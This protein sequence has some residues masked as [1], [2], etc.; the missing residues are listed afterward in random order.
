MR[1]I[2]LYLLTALV[3]A[4]VSTS[5][6]SAQ[7]MTDAE[8]IS[9]IKE[10]PYRA[11]ACHSPYYAPEVIYTPAPEG[12]E[13]F[14]VS[15]IGRHGSRFQTNGQEVY[16]TIVSLLDSLHFA[17]ALTPQGDSLRMELRH[18]QQAHLGMDGMLTGRGAAEHTGIA[19]RLAAR[20]PSVFNQADRRTV[21][22]TA[23]QKQRTIQSMAGFIAGLQ[24]VGGN[25]DY[26]INCGIDI[27]QYARPSDKPAN[28]GR[29]NT[30]ISREKEFLTPDDADLEALQHRLFKGYK[31]S[32]SDLETLFKASST[33]GCL[34]IKVDPFRFFSTEELFLFY[35]QYDAGF[36]AKYGT[37]APTRDDVA[38][39]GKAYLRMIVDEA[40]KALDGN[41]HCADFRFAHDT[42]LGPLMN[43]LGIGG[44]SISATEDAPYRYWQSF[45]QICMGSN[46][47]LE[48]YRNVESDVLVKALYNEKEVGFP[49]LESV[50]NVFYKWSD[51]RR[52]MINKCEELQEIPEYYVSHIRTKANEIR[53]LQKDELEGFYFITDMHFPDNRGHSAA[54]IEY[55]EQNVEKRLIVYGGDAIS[56][57]DDISEGMAMQISALEQMR[58]YSP[59]LW[60]RGNHDIVNYTGKKEWITGE[61]KTLPAWE[62]EKLLRHFRPVGAATNEADPY[63]AYF[64]YDDTSKKVRYIVFD[65]TDTVND[66]NKQSG[67]SDVQLEWIIEKAILEAPEEYGI[68]FISHKPFLGEED[69]VPAQDA[70]AAF[71]THSQFTYGGKTFDYS[72]RPD[73]RMLCVICGHKHDDYSFD[74]PGGQP[75]INVTS[76]CDYDWSNRVKDSIEDQ[77]FEYVSISTDGHVRTVRIG[78]GENREF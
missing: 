17:G 64:Y 59:I 24:S 51:V 41:G 4:N 5:M 49:G 45:N 37:F 12:Y 73:L 28:S 53:E 74:F 54:L 1:K 69:P 35:R 10:H 71:S 57:V 76:D 11:A 75:Q 25:L 6:V 2:Y 20:C 58:A 26:R 31:A 22:C 32:T 14:Y 42:N 55:L 15:H 50:N 29:T 19:G 18:I 9:A 48:F 39:K 13:A 36:N 30:I 60:A 66:D 61:R 78:K 34:D 40:D 47:Q 72:K 43:L 16:D 65:T 62:S 70:L 63:T 7:E 3:F 33:A 27:I 67:L 56:Y 68:V 21:S 52:Y 77:S 8:I 38:K 44:Y 23:T 46:L